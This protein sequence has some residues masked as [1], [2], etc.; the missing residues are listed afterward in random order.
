MTSAGRWGVPG[1]DGLSSVRCKFVVGGERLP[2]SCGGPFI[3]A[4]V[5]GGTCCCCVGDK[6]VVLFT[7]LAVAVDGV[8]VTD[9]VVSCGCWGSLASGVVVVSTASELKFVVRVFS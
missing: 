2:A 6:L 8:V 9:D 4:V 3:G 5:L 7:I 1:C